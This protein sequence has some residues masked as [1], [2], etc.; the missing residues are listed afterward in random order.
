MPNFQDDSQP[1]RLSLRHPASEWDDRLLNVGKHVRGLYGDVEAALAWCAGV[2]QWAPIP[3]GGSTVRLWELLASTAAADV[4]VARILEPHLDALAILDQ[5][6]STLSGNALDQIGVGETSTWG[7]YAAEG[8]ESTLTG[9]LEGGTWM[10]SGVKPWCSLAQNVSHS[11]VTARTTDGALRLFAVKLKAPGVEAETGPWHS[12]GLRQVVSAPVSFARV[13]AV[14]IGAEKWYLN[15]P[16][17][18]WG[19]LGVAACWWGGAIGIAR[20]LYDSATRREPDQ[21]ACAHLGAVDT[22][23]NAARALLAEASTAVDDPE[24][25]PDLVTVVTRRTRNLVAEAVESTITRVGHALGPALLTQNEEHA[26]RVADLQIYV[27]QH[28]AERDDASLGRHL[29]ARKCPPW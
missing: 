29:L 17:F 15:R 9:T 22:R 6:S 4:G 5:A 19:G 8:P 16:G 7:V 26:R 3:G 18:A 13:P 10:L 21:L 11:L 2:G 28:H 14:P 25:E 20:A 1:V 27:R 24:A 23:L 12:R